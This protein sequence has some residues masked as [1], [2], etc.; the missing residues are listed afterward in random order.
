MTGFEDEVLVEE[1]VEEAD[2]TLK[3]CQVMTER[4]ESSDLRC[5]VGHTRRYIKVKISSKDNLVNQIVSV[6]LN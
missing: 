5:F 6:K 3:T 1:E 2:K 4:N